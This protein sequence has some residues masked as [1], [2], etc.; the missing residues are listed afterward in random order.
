M[1]QSPIKNVVI[2]GG[3]SAGWMAAIAIAGRFPEKRI[4]VVDPKALGPIGVGESVTGVVLQFVAD[5]LHG[6]DKGEFFRRCDVTFKTGIW[7]KDWHGPGTE[8]LSPIDSPSPHFKYHYASHTEEFYAR[9]IADGANLGETQL[10]GLLMR[11]NQTD[12]FR[13]P[14]GKIN[15]KLASASCHFDALKFTAWLQEVGGRRENID[16]IDDVVETFDQEAESGHVTRIRTRTGLEVIG[17]LFIDCTGFHR[18]LFAKAYQPKWKSYADYIKV[19]SAIPTFSPYA[20]DQAPPNYTMAT[21]MPHGWMWQIP[22]QSRLGRGYIFSS[23]YVSDEQALADF[24]SRGADPGDNPRILRFSPGRFER[25]WEGNVC[26]IGLSGV[27]SEPLEASTIHGMYVQIRLLTELLLPFCT[28]ES[29]RCMADQYNYLT[30][31][32]YD[33]Y[34]DF[35]SFHYRTGRDDTEFWRD[36]QRPEALTLANQARVEKWKHAFPIREDF[37]PT[38]TQQAGHTTGLVIWA[39]MLCGFDL[40]VPEHARRMVELSR[41]P[42]M[43]QANVARYL[44]VRNHI[45]G[46]ALSHTEATQYFRDM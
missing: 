10:Y 44:Q 33:D 17:D 3:G 36:Y 1:D 15:D 28:Q 34:V 8:Y 29:M 6:L 14:D 20:P 25:L 9:A 30:T 46:T 5:P 13:D 37:V 23:R 27:F 40:L 41:H 2:I 45:L 21:A 39:P 24:R 22:T 11:R 35:I 19:D 16:H 4:T 38:Y 31:T 43:L 32:A 42:E 18:L 26:T 12:H 7:Y